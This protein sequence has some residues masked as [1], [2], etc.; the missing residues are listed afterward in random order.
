M[1]KLRM[2]KFEATSSP[3][4]Q[5]LIDEVNVVCQA[6]SSHCITEVIMYPQTLQGQGSLRHPSTDALVHSIL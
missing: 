5:I 2:G 4:T 1:Y 6:R 3:Q